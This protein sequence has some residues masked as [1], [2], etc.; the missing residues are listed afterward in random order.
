MVGCEGLVEQGNARGRQADRYEVRTQM[1]RSSIALSNLRAVVIVI[2]LAFHAMLAYLASLPATAHRFDDAPYLWQ[3]IP[4]V[5]SHRWFAFD[6][7]C[8]WQDVSLMSLMFFLSGLF[9][10]SSL[11]RKGGSTFLSDRFFRIGLPLVLVVMFL[12][13]VTYYPTYLA[14]AADPSVSTY[15]QHLTALP[16]WPCGPQWFLW[17]LLTLNVLAAGLHRFVPGWSE[18]LARLAASARN[19]PMRFFVALVAVSALA[20]VPLA[21]V[22]SPWTWTSYGPFSFQLSRP[23]H[24]LVYFFAGCAVGASGLDRGLLASDGALARHWAAWLAASIVGFVLW[25]LPTSLMVD[26]RAAPLMVQAAAALGFVLACASG[27]FVL[28]ALCLRFAPERTRIL[29][30]LSVNAYGIYLLHYVFIV[31]LQYLLLPLALFA[32]GKAGIVFGGTLA[33]SW[34]AAVAFGNV[35]WDNH[36]AQAKR[37]MRA[38][39][40]DPAPAKLAKQDDLTG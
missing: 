32:A 7:F 27:C 11:A 4:I 14:T 19:H 22:Y 8:A 13:P 10:P 16:F 9:V 30:S 15:W 31:W 26:G 2:V 5:D 1:S 6:L 36:L 35:S 20:Y 40:G 3:A 29:D 21:L 34:A 23:L 38:S 33:L 39:F 28:L 12:M 17:Q 24:Y 25:A 18:S 37:W